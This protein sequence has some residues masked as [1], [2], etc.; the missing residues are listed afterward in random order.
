MEYPETIDLHMHTS[1][2]DGT[3]TPEEIVAQ[4]KAAGLELFSVT[5]HDAVKGAVMIRDALTEND[6]CF[7][8]GVEF[9]CKD[10]GGK[11]HILGYGFDP[12]SR[13]VQRVVET[14]HAYRMKKVTARL[15]FL[16]TKFGFDFPK[17]ELDRLL[18]LDN[19]GKPHIGN[20]M[21]RY[22]YAESKEK[23]ISQ[24]ID[25]LRFRSEYVRPEEAI[26]GILGGGGIPVLAHPAYGSGDELILGDAMDRRLRHL[27]EFGLQGVEAFYSGFTDRLRREMLAFAERYGLY[28][29][30][31][32]DY[33]GANKLVRLGD[34]G[35][36]SASAG[37]DGLRR[38]L[39]DVRDGWS[40]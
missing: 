2:S 15:D 22:G 40:L 12:L 39:E 1:V 21:V 25:Q 24:Y 27:M 23:A 5:D 38:F 36:V 11:Y 30:A 14:G 26:Q 8:T 4:V 33:H 13:P 7:L 31:G 18:S 34:T 19:P 16:K 17:E 9:S 29:T 10:E 32:S 6:P 37:P 20:L 28:V 3:D 35:C